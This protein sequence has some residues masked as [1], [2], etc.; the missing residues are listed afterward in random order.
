IV[1]QH[2]YTEP[3]T[4]GVDRSIIIERA[5]IIE[6]ADGRASQFY[7]IDVDGPP[8]FLNY[9]Q[10]IPEKIFGRNLDDFLA[11]RLAAVVN[12]VFLVYSILDAENAGDPLERSADSLMAAAAGLDLIAAAAGW[13]LGALNIYITSG[14]GSS[15]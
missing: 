13:A 10:S 9:N 14:L 5:E 4:Y 1:D 8:R 2:V 12:L 3:S 7:K 6:T 11:T 15:I